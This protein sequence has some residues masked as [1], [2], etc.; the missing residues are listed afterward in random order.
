MSDRPPYGIFFVRAW[1]EDDQ[2]RARVTR[3]ADVSAGRRT[4]LVTADV[5]E[6]I[7]ALHEWLVEMSLNEPGPGRRPP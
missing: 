5:G 4:E 7:R 2:L 6:L 3:Y 1:Y